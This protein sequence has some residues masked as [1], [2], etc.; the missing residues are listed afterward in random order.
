MDT[1]DP[2]LQGSP[3]G[4][5]SLPPPRRRRWNWLIAVLVLLVVA[6]ISSEFFTL[7]YYAMAPGVSESV[8]PLI[9]VPSGK[10]HT[11]K[12]QVL[13][14]TV[15]LGPVRFP[16]LV[17][18]WFDPNVQIISREKILGSTKPS[19]LQQQNVQE[20][21][22]SK[23]AAV[24]VALRRLGYDVKETGTGALIEGVADGTPA[25]GRVKAGEAITAIDGHPTTLASDA[26]AIIHAHNP[27]DVVTLTVD[28][29]GGAAPRTEQIALGTH[30]VTA[31][32]TSCTST[33]QTVDQAFLGVGLGTRD[34]HVD[35]PVN[36][37]IDSQGIGGPSAG[38]A[39]TLGIMSQLATGD[40]AGGHKVAATGVINVDGT[41]S[42]VGGVPQT[43]VA[44]RHA[45]ADT[46]LVPCAEYQD[47]LKKAGKHLRVVPVATLE[48]ALTE[49]TAL[50]GS[51]SS[52]PAPPP[53]L[54]R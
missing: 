42:A 41:V 11:A 49:L 10:G 19:Q 22:D 35:L 31:P 27:G 5:Q 24:I 2:M 33:P 44:V 12:G 6:L 26:V 48:G 9:H 7:P 32:R 39:F 51:T 52:L 53:T 15:E 37:T 50:G 14:T 45:G 40:L 38:L 3:L 43:T 36:I 17:H 30:Q 18:D 34:E 54:L 47:A 1:L 28:P 46:V 23:Q 25:S 20:M 21:D 29:G 13:L 4:W 8:A 16:E